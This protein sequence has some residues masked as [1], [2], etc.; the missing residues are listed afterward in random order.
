MRSA[1][2]DPSGLPV[3]AATLWLS[4][5]IAEAPMKSPVLAV[6]TPSAERGRQLPK[7]ARIAQQ[8]DVSHEG[9]ALQLLVPD[10]AA[11]GHRRPAPTHHVL[12]GQVCGRRGCTLED[13]DRRGWSIDRHPADAVEEELERSSRLG[14]GNRSDSGADVEADLI[15]TGDHG[16]APR[17][18]IGLAGEVD[19]ERL[20]PPSGLQ[21]QRRTVWPER[22]HGCVRAEQVDSRLL[23]LVAHGWGSQVQELERGIGAS[24]LDERLRGGQG[25]LGAPLSDPGSSRPPARG[26]PL[27]RPSRRVPEPGRRSVRDRRRPPR[28]CRSSPRRGARHADPGPRPRRSPP[29]ARHGP[30][31]GRRLVRPGRPPTGPADA[32]SA[33]SMRPRRDRSL[34]PRSPRFPG[35]RGAARRPR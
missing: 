14:H 22:R 21:E 4:A 26:R 16:A 23:E 20:D 6:A 27:R 12:D 2:Y 30:P 11:G 9:R 34:P 24:G 32:G 18:Q 33:A 19:V 28:R 1:V 7:C 17:D 25:A 3:A 13:R 8:L 10:R 29:R 35:C 31:V 5:T 15:L